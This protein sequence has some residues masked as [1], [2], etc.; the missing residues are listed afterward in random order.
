MCNVFFA[1]H[2]IFIDDLINL[3]KMSCF[4]LVVCC[5]FLNSELPSLFPNFEFRIVSL[6]VFA[7]LE[8][9]APG[10]T[11]TRGSHFQFCEHGP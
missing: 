8:R 1:F 4:L 6:S 2:I 5:F 10:E 3:Y 11:L 9:R 7:E